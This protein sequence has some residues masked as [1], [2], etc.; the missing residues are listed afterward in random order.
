MLAIDSEILETDIAPTFSGRVNSICV[1]LQVSIRGLSAR[2][3]R[4]S[5]ISYSWSNFTSAINRPGGLSQLMI[6]VDSLNRFEVAAVNDRFNRGS[7]QNG[8][9]LNQAKIDT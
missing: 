8:S 2:F 5:L 6:R 4:T 7:R 9:L 3:F 1:R